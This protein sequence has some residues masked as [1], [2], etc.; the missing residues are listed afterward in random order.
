MPKTFGVVARPK[1]P[2]GY[3][4]FWV[5]VYVRNYRGKHQSKGFAGGSYRRRV[6]A[7]RIAKT[8]RHS[9]VYIWCP[10]P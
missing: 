1:A 3:V 6:D 10:K 5:N 4:G 8:R 9:C 7:D 2:T